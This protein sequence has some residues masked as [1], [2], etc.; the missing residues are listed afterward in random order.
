MS[1]K[2]DAYVQK[3]KARVDEWNAEIDRLSARAEQAEADARIQYDEEIQTLKKFR[4]DTR[5]KLEK[6]EKSGDDAWE[7]LKSGAEMAFE[8]MNEAINSARKR[9][10]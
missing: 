7:D 3:I 4:D 2:R 9:F 1:E 6:L 8:A 5:N 10:R